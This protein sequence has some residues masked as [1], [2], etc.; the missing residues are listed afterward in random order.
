MCEKQ[1]QKAQ[2][3]AI[4]VVLSQKISWSLW[5][6]SRIAQLNNTFERLGGSRALTTAVQ[7]ARP[8]AVDPLGVLLRQGDVDGRGLR[9]T[10]QG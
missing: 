7:R 1:F 5:E 9:K 8:A 2:N 10:R 3:Q 6:E 4:P